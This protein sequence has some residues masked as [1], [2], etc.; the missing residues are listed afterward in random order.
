MSYSVGGV[1]SAVYDLTGCLGTSARHW[2]SAFECPGVPTQHPRR[3]GGGAV[4]SRE[5]EKERKGRKGEKKPGLEG[6]SPPNKCQ[7]MPQP[8]EQHVVQGTFVNMTHG[9]ATKKRENDK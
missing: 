4:V 5:K 8:M 1:T 9:V 7:I 2:V 6:I 3:G